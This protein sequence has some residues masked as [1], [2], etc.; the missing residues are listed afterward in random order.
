MP[1]RTVLLKSAPA[2]RQFADLDGRV[3]GARRL[4][5]RR[6]EPPV[7]GDRG[8]RHRIGVAQAALD[9]AARRVPDRDAPG[10]P[11]GGEPAAVGRE[12]EPV[13]AIAVA[14]RQRAGEALRAQVDQRRGPV[15]LAGRHQLTARVDHRAR[16]R[17]APVVDRAPEEAAP[18]PPSAVRVPQA[19]RAVAGAEQGPP[20]GVQHDAV[21]EPPAGRVER[22][23]DVAC[24]HVPD[25]RA[26]VGA[27]DDPRAV[28]VERQAVDAVARQVVG[29]G[30]VLAR[31]E[32]Q[33]PHRWS[34]GP[35]S[36]GRCGRGRRARRPGRSRAFRRSGS[37]AGSALPARPRRSSLPPRRR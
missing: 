35:R 12:R 9:G 3:G 36:R 31:A 15:L 6:E 17:E 4:S 23:E 7:G 8:P 22:L 5:L 28:A 11:A 13:R 26:V 33:H 14:G 21:A 20:L 24:L 27:A 29:Q 16:V 25:V 32:V 19:D 18:E 37:A 34:S 10:D 1:K 2:R 30:P